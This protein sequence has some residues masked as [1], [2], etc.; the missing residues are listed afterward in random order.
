[1]EISPRTLGAQAQD[2]RSGGAASGARPAYHGQERHVLHGCRH[3]LAKVRGIGWGGDSGSPWR[4][5]ARGNKTEQRQRRAC[6]SWSHGLM[7]R[8]RTD[9]DQPALVTVRTDHRLDRRHRLFVGRLGRRRRGVLQRVTFG[10][11]LE[12]QRLPDAD[13]VVALCGM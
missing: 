1:M 2:H 5:G 12:L 11:R 6:R 8:E 7:A 4:T 10:W 13:G 9:E 3:H